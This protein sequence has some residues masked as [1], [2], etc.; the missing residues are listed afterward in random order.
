MAVSAL[1]TFFDF[2]LEPSGSYTNSD[3]EKYGGSV[4]ASMRRSTVSGSEGFAQMKLPSARESTV[5]ESQNFLF[6]VF[7]MSTSPLVPSGTEGL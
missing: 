5:T 1:A 3:I 7:E 6:D 2:T 4:S